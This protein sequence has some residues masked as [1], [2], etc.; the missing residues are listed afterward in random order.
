M[1]LEVIEG[2]FNDARLRFF[3]VLFFVKEIQ[4]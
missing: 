4:V 3:S 2:V 1:F